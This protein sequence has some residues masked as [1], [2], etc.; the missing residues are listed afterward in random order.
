MNTFFDNLENK[1]NTYIARSLKKMEEFLI[2]KEVAISAS[3]IKKLPRIQIKG[4]ASNGRERLLQEEIQDDFDIDML[5]NSK[6]YNTIYPM[7]NNGVLMFST[8]NEGTYY[9]HFSVVSETDDSYNLEI[10]EYK[11]L[12]GVTYLKGIVFIEDISKTLPGSIGT[13][14]HKG[15]N[16]FFIDA[17]S[18][19]ELSEFSDFELECI[20]CEDIS[21]YTH[22]FDAVVKYTLSTFRA[23]NFLNM[24]YVKNV[25]GDSIYDN[26]YFRIKN[27]VFED[28]VKKETHFYIEEKSEYIQN[29]IQDNNGYKIIHNSNVEK[30]I[31]EIIKQKN[32]KTFYSAVGFAFYSGL[33]MIE[34]SICEIKN[35]K[36]ECELIVGALQNY[37]NSHSKNIIDKKT[38]EYL[39]LLIQKSNVK[40]YTHIESFY[41]GK[42]YYMCN[43]EQAFIIIGSSNIS[44][45]AFQNKFELDVIHIVHRGREEDNAF[46]NWYYGLRN[47]CQYIDLLDENSFE[48]RNWASELDIFHTLKARTISINEMKQRI[49]DITEEEKKFRLNLWLS[50]KPTQMHENI[51]IESLKEYV[52]FVFSENN[53]VVFDSL[54]NNN[55]YYVFKNKSSLPKLLT[56]IK[57]MTK[58]QMSLSEHY[59]NKGYHIK[60]KDKI[61]KKIE[62]FFV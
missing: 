22:Y 31:N 53:L 23:I 50:K 38:A 40:L 15:I 29:I 7:L 56:D 49:N 39:N 20:K 43:D 6:E 35:R 46:L 16:D 17:F 1:K 5:E 27:F 59:V 36:G 57:E 51:D 28:S 2:D 41:H 61:K 11:L 33:K 13:V 26:R 48:E 55:A 12:N 21:K 9:S 54:M 34:K 42:F 60:D 14:K 32:I 4:C 45:T 10:K 58:T 3:E 24:M 37:A 62:Q 8:H 25:D 52:M 30:L 18:K 44:K 47:N 19:K